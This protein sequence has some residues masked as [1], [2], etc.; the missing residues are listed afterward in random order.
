MTTLGALNTVLK[1]EI[2]GAAAPGFGLNLGFFTQSID[3]GNSRIDGLAINRFSGDGIDVSTLNGGVVIA[4]SFLGTDV[5]GTI[6]LG[7]RGSGIYLSLE[8]NTTIGGAAAGDS[9]LIAGNDTDGIELLEPLGAT[10]T[11]NVFATVPP[12]SNT[13]KTLR[14]KGRGIKHKGGKHGDELVKL[15]V[16]MP[17]RIDEDLKAFAEE[18]RAKHGY[19]PRRKL[20]EQA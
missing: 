1:I 14:L 12:G 8:D 2:D 20:R 18:W 17:D 4:G 10:I 13:G 5:S 9:N 6:D 3:A 19:D 15:V 16:M 11:G 7:N